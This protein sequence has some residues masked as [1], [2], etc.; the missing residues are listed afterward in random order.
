MPK[1]Y[2]YIRMS[3]P[4]QITGDSLRRQ[5]AA[6]DAYALRK[7]L[8]I[9][10]RFDDIGV[11]GFRGKNAQI[12]ALKNFLEQ[13][14]SGKIAKGSYL[15]VESI[16][17]LSR[18]K[19]SNA[20]AL[21]T[22]I[23]HA[24]IVVV[25]L[26]ENKEFSTKNVDDDS[27]SLMYALLSMV[28]AH[29]ESRRKS[30]M[31]GAAWSEKRSEARKIGKPLTKL[32]PAWLKMK[33][34]RLGYEIIHERAE[35]VRRI[36]DEILAGRGAGSIAKD[37]T[38]NGPKPWG[39]SKV[40]NESYIKKIADSLAVFGD[41]QPHVYKE[42]DQGNLK[43]VPE[44]EPIVGYYPAIL[45]KETF[46]RA[47]IA[48]RQRRVTGRGRKGAAFRNPLTGL[49]KCRCGSGIQFIDKG[50]LPK[51]GTYLRCSQAVR[52][53]DC[54]CPAYKFDVV[55]QVIIGC[56][57]QLDVRR[58]LNNNES[59]VQSEDIAN[60]LQALRGER[61][62]SKEKAQRLTDAIA[63]GASD[64]PSIVIN[65]IREQ[66]RRVIAIDAEIKALEVV[67]ND[68]ITDGYEKRKSNVKH[69]FDQLSID[70]D[71]EDQ[72]RLRM[73]INSELRSILKFIRIEPDLGLLPDG[74][75]SLHTRLDGIPW[76]KL[77]SKYRNLED[78]LHFK[79]RIAYRNG[80]VDQVEPLAGTIQSLEFSRKQEDLILKNSK[81]FQ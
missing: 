20:L 73:Q 33:S 59:K 27:F 67:Q 21:L 63:D 54:T 58:F 72:A 26:S 51:G 69:L 38:M 60:K 28:R 35:I 75:P 9:E 7:G 70:S 10:Q 65:T 16:D 43:R 12:G 44:G 1:A 32:A 55:L 18:D 48:M 15:I 76:E 64:M 14:E 6:A 61:Q 68:L 29:D 40:W 41:Y 39:R 49:M 46:L 17:R 71:D 53:G 45:D 78:H 25:A 47:K 30:S 22:S 13:V 52:K 77:D 8:E 79:F 31:L 62:L 24:G 80:V 2:S 23:I 19:V 3:T 56:V 37:L 81:K 50:K 4:E 74:V 42:D 34:D 57:K 36:F 11:S 5:I 66:E